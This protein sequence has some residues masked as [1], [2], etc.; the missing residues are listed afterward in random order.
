MSNNNV[1]A[2]KVVAVLDKHLSMDRKV[3]VI[4]NIGLN[5]HKGLELVTL[6]MQAVHSHVYDTKLIDAIQKDMDDLVRGVL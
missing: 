5:E 2:E 6:V 4:Q 3:Q 1:L